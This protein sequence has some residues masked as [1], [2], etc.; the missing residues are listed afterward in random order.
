MDVSSAHIAQWTTWIER[1]VVAIVNVSDTAVELDGDLKAVHE[2][3]IMIRPRGRT[4]F[5]MIETIDLESLE[6]YDEKPKRIEPKRMA[7]VLFGATRQHLADRHGWALDE[8]NSPEFTEARAYD[9]HE[10][11]HAPGSDPIS[12]FHEG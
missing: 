3:G 8:L 9:V 10:E 1:R 2:R 5:E 12:H 6:L 7:H 4:S 11:E